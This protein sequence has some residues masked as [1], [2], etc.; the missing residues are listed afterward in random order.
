MASTDVTGFGL[1]FFDAFAS[2]DLFPEDNDV[3][4]P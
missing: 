1:L 3:L 2:D 4:D